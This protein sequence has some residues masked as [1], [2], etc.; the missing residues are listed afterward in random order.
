MC[1]EKPIQSRVSIEQV[2]VSHVLRYFVLKVISPEQV[3]NLHKLPL[4]GA[5]CSV[6][7][8]VQ[9]GDNDS[10]RRDNAGDNESESAAKWA[11]LCRRVRIV[12]FYC[13]HTAEIQILHS[14]R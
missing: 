7:A 3:L 13:G 8:C 10:R 11:C 14:C 2:L 5:R 4:N 12:M 1:K 9:C 6:L